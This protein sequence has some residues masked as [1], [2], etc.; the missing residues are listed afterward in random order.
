MVFNFSYKSRFL[1]LFKFIYYSVSTFNIMLY[2]V[3][4]KLNLDFPDKSMPIFGW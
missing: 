2:T 3:K 1:F 4:G